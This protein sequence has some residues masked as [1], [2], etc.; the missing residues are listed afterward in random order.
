MATFCERDVFHPPISSIEN[1][2]D[3][4]VLLQS[5]QPSKGRGRG[6]VGCKARAR[7]RNP[8]AS[9]L[10]DQLIKE[11]VSYSLRD[12][13]SREEFGSKAAMAQFAFQFGERFIRAMAA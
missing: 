9:V 1:P 6:H 5:I 3:K 11:H 2:L 10:L 7:R 4:V 8:S 12:E 13:F